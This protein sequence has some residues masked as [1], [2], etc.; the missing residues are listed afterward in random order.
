MDLDTAYIEPLLDDWLEGLQTVIKAQENLVKA[1]DEFYMPFVAIPVP[2]VNAIFK[3]TEHLDLGPDTRYIAIHLYD[4]FMCNYF[5]EIYKNSDQTENTWSQICK[6][7]S[8]QSKL[9]LMSC[10]QLASKMD[11]HSKN[12]RISQVLNLL[13]WI[14][15]K[16][17]YTHSAIFSSEYKVF[18]TV[19]FRMPFC[20]PLNCI[21]VLLA[22]TGL[23]DTPNMQELTINLLDLVYL[24]REKVYSNLQ[25]L[26]QGHVARTQEEKRSLMTLES[27]VL[28]LGA[29]VV[30][31]GTFFF[32][33]DSE[34]AKVIA[35]KLSQLI[36]IKF[37]DIWNMANILLVMAIQE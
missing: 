36:D 34:T 31:C 32:C 18:K 33:I 6:K 12:L 24:Q 7:I 15:K 37:N 25:C 10:L 1:K 21:E 11:S 26:I 14:D 20:T 4:K 13:R 23:K 30:L 27:N 17:E 35:L 22:A 29:S 16:S 5:W 28:F 19:G 3:V 8:S 2:I 9:Y